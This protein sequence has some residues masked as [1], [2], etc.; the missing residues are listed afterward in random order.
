MQHHQLHPGNPQRDPEKLRA[1]ASWY[2]NAAG[3]KSNP[4]V[5]EGLLS[6]AADLDNEAK[7]LK[8]VH[9]FY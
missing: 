7:R 2:R 5:R 3:Q 4:M 6:K 1:L 9:G 8:R